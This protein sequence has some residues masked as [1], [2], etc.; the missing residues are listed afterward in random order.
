MPLKL[1][2]VLECHI[3]SGMSMLGGSVLIPWYK[4]EVHINNDF[5][6]SPTG[7]MLV[8][9]TLGAYA[10]K[11]AYTYTVHLSTHS[12]LNVF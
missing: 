3:D 5:S 4:Y 10:L 9:V 11:H 7:S 2:N 1:K 12:L 6:H 8:F